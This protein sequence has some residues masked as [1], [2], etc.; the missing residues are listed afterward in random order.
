MMLLLSARPAAALDPK[1]KIQ[2]YGHQ[3]WQTENGLPQNSVHAIVQSH[4]GY[5]WLGTDAGLVRFDGV[6]F[7]VFDKQNTPQLSNNVIRGLKEDPSGTLWISTAGGLTALRASRFTSYS[8]NDGLPSDSVWSV[9][10]G[11]SGTV[12]VVTA[13]GLARFGQGRFAVQELPGPPGTGINAVLESA[14][15][16]LWIATAG[17]LLRLHGGKVETVTSGA[18]VRVLAEGTGDEVW[19]GTRD[20]LVRITGGKSFTMTLRD[21]LPSNSVE[22]LLKDRSGALWVGTSA[23]LARL[24][25]G[26]LHAF[27]AREGALAG[28]IE[29]IFEDREGSLWLSS[30]RGLARLREGRF[31]ELTSEQGLSS[32][33]ILTLFEDR[34]GDLWIG[35]EAG[36]LNVLRDQK[37]YTFTSKD[38]LANDLARAVFQDRNGDIWIG[39]NGG[40]VSRLHDGKFTSYSI[41][42]GLSSDIVFA[43]AGD[44]EGNLWVGTPDGLNRFRDGKWT[45]FTAA[46]GLADDFVRSIFEDKSGVLWIGTRRG[47]SRYQGGHFNSYSTKD[48]LPSEF[49]GTLLDD[50]S[51]GLWIGTLAGLSHFKDGKFQNYGSKDGLSSEA[52]TSLYMDKD[53]ALWIGTNGAGLNRWKDGKVTSYAGQS[54]LPDV[55]YRTLEDGQHQFWISSPKGIFRVGKKQLEDLAEGHGAPITP[56]VY[57]TSDGMKISECSEGGHPSGWKASDGS[58]W[59]STIKGVAMVD[60]EHLQENKVPPL[61]VVE[62]VAADGQPVPLAERIEIGPKLDRLAFSF[63]GLS[64]VAPQK[65]RYRYRLDGYDQEWVEAGARRTAFYTNLSPGDYVFRVMAANNDGVWSEA[66]AAY[67]FRLRPHFYQTLWFYLLCALALAGII[68]QGYRMRM[69]Q[70]ESRFAAVLAERT[71]IAREMH[72]TLAQGFVGISLQLELASKMLSVSAEAAKEQMDQARIVVRNSLAEARRSLWD[73][74]S[75][76][77]EKADL[78]TALSNTAKQLTAQTPVA[79]QFQVTGTFRP[80]PPQVENELLRIGQEAV[81]NAVR[82]A[83]PKH[84][85]IELSYETGRVG[86]SVRDDGRGF[87]P[88]NAAS[89]NGHFGLV[90]MKERAAQIQ[91]TLTVD[92]RPGEGTAIK[93]ECTIE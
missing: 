17:G 72:D 27:G 6:E 75:Q 73:L 37:F 63:A 84:I 29:S 62:Q 7:V 32:N 16:P 19:A 11:R 46:D 80:L 12:W 13:G 85:K 60:P 25:N 30:A 20:G 74:R 3:V 66:G 59:F 26:K 53:R 8:K 65:V 64:F 89:L 34:E 58:L 39:T 67:P 45:T 14:D 31:E 38:G 88:A 42:N 82:H 57:G 79:L 92:S 71:R 54:K 81:T 83:Q 23:G 5:L 51:G 87:D 55:V 56:E 49:I 4:D 21:G 36:G 69:R 61:V 43:L 77:L 52:I 35:T 68:W 9:Y 10:V 28:R 47:L 33:I 15:G 48:G 44:H 70:I 93:V 91:G 90:G 22:S 86:L 18:D 40:G 2:M 50:G 78:P 24:E 41:A 1:K 76:Q